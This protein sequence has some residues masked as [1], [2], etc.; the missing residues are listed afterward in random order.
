MCSSWTGSFPWYLGQ[1][2]INFQDNN[3][4]HHLFFPMFSSFFCSRKKMKV[5][6]EDDTLI[7]FKTPHRKWRGNLIFKTLQ[8]LQRPNVRGAYKLINMITEYQ[9]A[10]MSLGALKRQQ[11]NPSLVFSPIFLTTAGNSS[12]V[13]IPQ[14]HEGRLRFESCQTQALSYKV[15]S[16]KVRYEQQ[17]PPSTCWVTDLLLVKRRGFFYVWYLCKE[18]VSHW[19]L[20]RW[21]WNFFVCRGDCVSSGSV[22]ST[23][24]C[25]LL[26]VIKKC[27]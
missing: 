13:I 22:D 25:F 20:V 26:L 18:G 19:S 9:F 27:Q 1:R 6:S 21:D 10:L 24:F 16:T 12:S 8:K 14:S 2:K 23:R 4:I 15:L 7:R 11:C 3:S 17:E 5:P